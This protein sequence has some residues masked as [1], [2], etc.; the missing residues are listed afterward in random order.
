VLYYLI[1]KFKIQWSKFTFGWPWLPKE[2]VAKILLSFVLLGLVGFFLNL[3]YQSKTW[4]RQTRYELFKS[5]LDDNRH[6][7][8]EITELIEQRLFA[9]QRFMWA[10]E[11]RKVIE[12]SWEEYMEVVQKWN[13]N[14]Q[15]LQNKIAQMLGWEMASQ[16]LTDVKDLENEEPK[17]IHYKFVRIH[18]HLIALRKCYYS[19]CNFENDLNQA[20]KLIED[21]IE[22]ETKFLGDLNGAIIEKYTK[23]T[24]DPS[25]FLDNMY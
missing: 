23:F 6:T 22:Q 19:G 25:K 8:S 9:T 4:N 16:F 2:E 10:V 5:E 1:M 7:L 15:M 11:D 17:S 3:F 18:E 24:R 21:L 20:T 14:D 13:L 12:S